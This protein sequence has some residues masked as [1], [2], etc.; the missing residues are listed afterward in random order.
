MQQEPQDYAGAFNEDIRAKVSITNANEQGMH[1]PAGAEME[2]QTHPDNDDHVIRRGLLE[3]PPETS[4]LL[5]DSWRAMQSL[6]WY[7][8]HVKGYAA[9]DS[10]SYGSVTN[11]AFN[12][13][14]VCLLDSVS[15][16]WVTCKCVG[17]EG[18]EPI[19]PRN[20]QVWSGVAYEDEGFGPL[21][22]VGATGNFVM[23]GLQ[24]RFLESVVQGRIRAMIMEVDYSGMPDIVTAESTFRIRLDQKANSAAVQ[25]YP[26]E[27]LPVR[28]EITAQYQQP[29]GWRELMT[30]NDNPCVE[31]TEVFDAT[32]WGENK[33]ITIPARCAAPYADNTPRRGV[34][35]TFKIER[36]EDGSIYSDV[37]G[38]FSAGALGNFPR[39]RIFAEETKI[40][41]GAYKTG[42]TDWTVG[43]QS[44]R[45][46]TMRRV[47]N[48]EVESARGPHDGVY[49]QWSQPI[50]SPMTLTITAQETQPETGLLHICKQHR[51]IP[52]ANREA[53][54]WDCSQCGDPELGGCPK[55]E[56]RAPSAVDEAFCA[57][58][59]SGQDVQLTQV[60]PGMSGPGSFIYERIKDVFRVFGTPSIEWF[61]NT[62]EHYTP[63]YDTAY[64]R[65]INP[66]CGGFVYVD[67][68]NPVTTENVVDDN[69]DTIGYHESIRYITG[70]WENLFGAAEAYDW[71]DPAKRFVDLAGILP[72]RIGWRPLTQFSE[73]ADDTNDPAKQVQYEVLMR[74]SAPYYREG[75]G[76][77]VSTRL[78]AG[79][80][81]ENRL[82]R[83]RELTVFLSGISKSNRA[84]Q[85]LKNDSTIQIFQSARTVDGIEG[86]RAVIQ[87]IPRGANDFGYKRIG[88]GGA[89]GSVWRAESIGDDLVEIHCAPGPWMATRIEGSVG[90]RYTGYYT[91]YG[92]G[93]VVRLP[94]KHAPH[95][96]YGNSINACAG[97]SRA[98]G[99]IAGD[100]LEINGKRYWIVKAMPCVGDGFRDAETSA[101]SIVAKTLGPFVQFFK[102][103]LSAALSVI[104][105]ETEYT[106]STLGTYA[107]LDPG[108]IRNLPNASRPYDYAGVDPI[109]GENYVYVDQVVVMN[110]DAART[111]A[112]Y[113]N[114]GSGNAYHTVIASTA[115]GRKVGDP[116][117]IEGTTGGAVDGDWIVTGLSGADIF[118]INQ[119]GLGSSGTVGNWW[120]IEV[121]SYIT[122]GSHSIYPH[123]SHYGLAAF[124]GGVALGHTGFKVNWTLNGAE[125]TPKEIFLEQPKML[126]MGGLVGINTVTM[127]HRR[128]DTGQWQQLV[129]GG[130]ADGGAD[131]FINQ[132]VFRWKLLSAGGDYYAVFHP[133]LLGDDVLAVYE[134]TDP[135]DLASTGEPGI[136]YH[137]FQG[138][139]AL[140]HWG[141]CDVLTVRD[142]A[143]ELAAAIADETIKQ[144]TLFKVSTG[145]V[146][147]P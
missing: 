41:L 50:Y 33:V 6:L 66:Q 48:Y 120:P 95:H 92:G 55:F 96:A 25:L 101:Q 65:R 97:G 68:E 111:I 30:L 107:A 78:T 80:E 28:V 98:R 94:W 51:E 124:R 1:F 131:F 52:E 10:K 85:G 103:D 39:V 102:A 138:G 12:S 127:W 145:G 44:F 93:N 100:T 16:Y 31:N 63:N 117:H 134:A 84:K 27:D 11:G 106:G 91:W 139:M 21:V 20:C 129:Y 73:D 90:D 112:N 14:F 43:A 34:R 4:T 70:A 72:R 8:H 2:T 140:D 108:L 62:A 61:L 32:D 17:A 38:S 58:I 74:R 82:Q 126:F 15:D 35:G 53:F 40:F 114:G 122:V 146:V 123:S 118:L 26:D 9:Q 71:T 57:Q 81:G 121:G 141:F 137:T 67:A 125:Q 24:V 89:S 83:V 130:A 45:V 76:V 116:V 46:R 132:P 49:C 42:A 59:T 29:Q 75:R 109:T 133:L 77:S 79:I 13:S 37:T 136:N 115:H 110:P 47:A 99:A 135:V 119:V 113:Y 144:G 143:G 36:S 104:S 3:P 18:G 7:F 87:L 88:Q 60:G 147:A 142:E 128:R 56:L 105:I 64:I 86:V 54:A 23:P 5:R 69:G 22:G 19:D